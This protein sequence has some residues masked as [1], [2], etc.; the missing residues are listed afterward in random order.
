MH[1][2]TCQMVSFKGTSAQSSSGSVRKRTGVYLVES[3]FCHRLASANQI[4]EPCEAY[5]VAGEQKSY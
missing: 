4:N 3:S 5:T 1:N 2:L